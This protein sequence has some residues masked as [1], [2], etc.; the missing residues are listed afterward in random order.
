MSV[1][2]QRESTEYLYIGVN[3]TLPDI[4][5]E[6]AFLLAGERPEEEDWHTAELVNNSSHPLWADATAA[7]T[8]EYFIALLLGPYE[9]SNGAGVV[10]PPGDYTVW[11]R[12]TASAE[13]PVRI[14]PVALEVQ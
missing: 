11:V 1:V 3:G 14:V 8:G 13:R 2:I 12:L 4:D 10:L 6:V 7:A 9:G 5:Q